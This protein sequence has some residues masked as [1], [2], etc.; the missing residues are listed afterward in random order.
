[1]SLIGNNTGTG[2]TE[3]PVG[4]PD[5]NG[6]LIGGGTSGVINPLLGP[7]ANNGGPTQT[8]GLLPGSPAI[9]AG[10][11]TLLPA[12]VNDLDGDG[13]T[14]EAIPFDQRG[15]GFPRVADGTVDMGAVE[16]STPFDTPS[17]LVTTAAD[18]FDSTDGVTSLREAIFFASNGLATGNTITFASG[19][20]DAFENGGVIR[21]TQGSQ[22]AL[23]GDVPTD[24]STAGGTRIITCDVGNNDTKVGSS[25]ITNAITNA[26]TSDNVRVLSITGGTVNLNDLTITGGFT[27]SDGGGILVGS[28]ATLNLSDSTV[29][30]NATGG[31]GDG[32]GIANYGTTNI[33]DSTISANKGR[34]G[35][36]VINSTA[37]IMTITGSTIANNVATN[38]GGGVSNFGDTTLTNVTISGNSSDK[39]GG[40]VYNGAGDTITINNTTVFENHADADGNSTGTGGGVFNEPSG[41]ATLNHTIVAG[42]TSGGDLSGPFAGSFNLVQD[43]QNTGGLTDTVIGDP[44]LGDLADNGG[45]TMTHALLAGSPAYEAGDPAAV[46]GQNGVPQF[47]QRGTGFDRVRGRLDIGAFESQTEIGSFVVSTNLDVVDGND[48]VTSLREA[49]A[50]ANLQTGADTITFDASVFDGG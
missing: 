22:L 26:N 28:G 8:H 17:L 13:D 47:D 41:T 19:A 32:G 7:V 14:T 45:P 35:G 4:S 5:A 50:F 3:A 46:A 25:M 43:D 44:M 16:T 18:T 9:N 1:F 6:N 29:T 49:I 23:D 10:N 42:S 11:N 27:T 48:L 24:G 39:D 38:D 37:D 40:G 33:A 21:L 2:L 30:G 12:D 31:N 36:G 20:G 34:Y 15:A